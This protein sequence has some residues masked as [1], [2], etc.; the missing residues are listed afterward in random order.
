MRKQHTKIE[1]KFIDAMQGGLCRNWSGW[2]INSSSRALLV[3]INTIVASLFTLF[4]VHWSFDHYKDAR[5]F[6]APEFIIS[7]AAAASIILICSV[8]Y[9]RLYYQAY[10]LKERPVHLVDIPESRG[11]K[12][13]ELY[14]SINSQDTE[15]QS[16][17]SLEK[18]AELYAAEFFYNSLINPRTVFTRINEHVRP[19]SKILKCYTDYELHPPDKRGLKFYGINDYSA[20]DADGVSCYLTVPVSFTSRHDVAMQQD[21]TNTSG[22]RLPRV[23]QS[24]VSTLI[25]QM[26]EKYT[27]GDGKTVKSLPSW[28]ETLRDS[29][30]RYLNNTTKNPS[31]RIARKLYDE[32][33]LHCVRCAAD[34]EFIWRM[35]YLLAGLKDVVPVCVSLHTVAV[36]STVGVSEASD[37]GDVDT[38]AQIPARVFS[39]R[40]AQS[41]ETK[42]KPSNM[43]PNKNKGILISAINR[44]VSAFGQRGNTIYYSLARAGRA[45]SYHLY[46]EGPEGTYYSRGSLVLDIPPGRIPPPSAKHI[47]MQSRCGQKNAHVYVRSGHRMSNVLFMFRYN[48]IP[49]DAYHLVFAACVLCA[50]VLCACALTSLMLAETTLQIT[51]STSYYCIYPTAFN[52]TR[53]A[54]LSVPTMVLAIATGIGPWAYSKASQGIDDSLGAQVSTVVLTACSVCAIL[55]FFGSIATE[56]AAFASWRWSLLIAIMLVNCAFTGAISFLH[57]ILYYHLKNKNPSGV[58]DTVLV[59]KSRNVQVCP[60][61]FV[62]R[63]TPQGRYVGNAY[64][65]WTTALRNYRTRED[66][67]GIA[68]PS[69]N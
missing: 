68:E 66:P 69:C 50:T 49:P 3:T 4:A 46:L 11:T 25:L 60:Q 56:N 27:F 58:L 22:V 47:K 13:R 53:L 16:S 8:L 37:P 28:D 62:R 54:G 64:L 34:Q 9:K 2:Q 7:C 41:L 10:E 6:L 39:L 29:I 42:R 32:L 67:Y 61:T 20:K 5:W 65:N 43:V 57:S 51:A 23:K 18:K 14:G 59:P 35:S 19:D 12:W 21:A 15:D 44:L 26:I 31:M 48:K 63:D 1:S 24:E 30:E 33:S 55:L 17:T 45:E 40:Y 36:A 52:E 38:G